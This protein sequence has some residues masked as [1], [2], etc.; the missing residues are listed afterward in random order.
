MALTVIQ[1]P[2][3]HVLSTTANT[4]TVTSSSGALFTDVAHGL[5]PGDYIYVYSEVSSYNGY[6]YVSDTTNDTFKI[7]EYNTA[8]AESFVVVTTVT[9]YTSINTHGWS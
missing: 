2:Q 9:Y 4:A 7:K 1:R 6:W 3:G 8:T 5:N